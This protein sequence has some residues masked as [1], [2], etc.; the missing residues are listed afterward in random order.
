MGNRFSHLASLELHCN[1]RSELSWSELF[2]LRKSR[3]P[4][5]T[6]SDTHT[7]TQASDCTIPNCFHR[8]DS[9]VLASVFVCVYKW[10]MMHRWI[11]VA[12]IVFGGRI[13]FSFCHC[14]SCRCGLSN[15][16]RSCIRA[17]LIVLTHC[18]KTEMVEIVFAILCKFASISMRNGECKAICI[19]SGAPCMGIFHWNNSVLRIL[20]IPRIR[21]N[22]SR[23]RHLTTMCPLSTLSTPPTSNIARA[24]AESP[25]ASTTSF[26]RLWFSAI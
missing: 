14:T 6:S 10:W 19:D 5:S 11:D 15:F 12:A 2:A 21:S 22:S 23:M 17:P 26:T 18:K 24:S 13:H 25:R 16:L 9:I 7:H 1:Y 4:T 20:R 8:F 3:W